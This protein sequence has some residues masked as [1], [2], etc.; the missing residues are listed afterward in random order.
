MKSVVGVDSTFSAI[1]ALG[2]VNQKVL[3]TVVDTEQMVRFYLQRRCYWERTSWT[4]FT[5]IKNTI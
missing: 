3:K 5:Y 4:I 1:D 2:G